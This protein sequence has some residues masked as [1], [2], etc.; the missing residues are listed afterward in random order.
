MG[1]R[2]CSSLWGTRES[3]GVGGVVPPLPRCR[4]GEGPS[5]QG[6]E[7]LQRL[8]P[9]EPCRGSCSEGG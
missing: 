5:L 6:C 9:A 2:K 8:G 1:C 4:R 7:R 3:H